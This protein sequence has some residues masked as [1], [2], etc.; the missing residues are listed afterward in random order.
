[1]EYIKNE[2]PKYVFITCDSRNYNN[3]FGWCEAYNDDFLLKNNYVFYGEITFRK[4]K[5]N[6][7]HK[8]FSN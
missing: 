4:E 6:K 1:M 3:M 2:N 8:I 7:L 5:L